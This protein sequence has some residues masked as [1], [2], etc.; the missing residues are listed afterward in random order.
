[1]ANYCSNQSL[2]APENP[3]FNFSKIILLDYIDTSALI[4]KP[5]YWVN[6]FTTQHVDSGATQNSVTLN[7]MNYE[8]VCGG[9]EE[10]FGSNEIRINMM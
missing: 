7:S 5:I 6:Y 3:V 9:L 8:G 4:A 10:L 2:A 1:M